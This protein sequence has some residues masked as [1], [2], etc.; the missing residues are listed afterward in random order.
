MLIVNLSLQ[1]AIL[2]LSN[3]EALAPLLVPV[4]FV[5]VPAVLLTLGPVVSD[6]TK[7]AFASLPIVILLTEPVIPLIV[8]L[9][10]DFSGINSPSTKT[11]NLLWSLT[12]ILK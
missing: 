8:S 10:L 9:F 11:L 12:S 5:Y 4:T 6:N 3:F 7:N 2:I 1:F